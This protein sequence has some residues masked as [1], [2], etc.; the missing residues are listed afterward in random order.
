M[1][2]ISIFIDSFGLAAVWSSTNAAIEQE[3]AAFIQAKTAGWAD[4]FAAALPRAIWEKPPDR[5]LQ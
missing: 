1:V 2:K 5:L 4:Y 3:R